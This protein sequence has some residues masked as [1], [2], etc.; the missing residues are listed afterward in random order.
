MS[1]A[2]HTLAID[3]GGTGLKAS[4]VDAHDAF[5]GERVRVETPY[6]CPPERLVGALV[7]LVAPLVP[8]DRVSVGFP[9]MV[10]AGLVLSAP[11]FVTR[12]GPGTEVVAALEVAWHRFD[13]AAAIAAALGRPAKVANDADVQGAAVVQGE[14]LELVVTLGTGLG[15]AVFHEGRLAPHLELAHH[16]FRKGETYNEQVGDDARKRIGTRKWNRRVQLAVDQLDAL[17]FFDRLYV[18]G[19][20]SHR[21]TVDLG[22]KATI[23]D[24]S[25]GILGGVRLWERD[26]PVGP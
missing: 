19:G 4:V 24:N 25:A 11:H 2:P 14:G 8:F 21:V 20:N 6:P 18:G 17:L 12:D 3:V 5:V 10:R 23:V 26:S 15:T 22:P 16:P 7:A 13:L 1:N 9:G